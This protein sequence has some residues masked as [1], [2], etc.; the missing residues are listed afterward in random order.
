M[1]EAIPTQDYEPASAEN[2]RL[3]AYAQKHGLTFDEAVLFLATS[4]LDMR[5]LGERLGVVMPTA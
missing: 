2:Q 5:E 3:M 4:A 1:P